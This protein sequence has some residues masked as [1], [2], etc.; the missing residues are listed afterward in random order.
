MHCT[1]SRKKTYRYGKNGNSRFVQLDTWLLDS[2]AWL[3]L[4]PAPRALYVQLKRLYNGHN[5]GEIYLSHRE[6]SKLLNVHRN[7]ISG[8]FQEL[9]NHGF[10]KQTQRHYLGPS[11]IGQSSKWVLTEASYLGKPATKE[12]MS[13]KQI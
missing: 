7:S 12:F 8:Y 9:Q 5:N 2:K 1:M 3:S 11:G 4:K 13:Y 6:A 10:I